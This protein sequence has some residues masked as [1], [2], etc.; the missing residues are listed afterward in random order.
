MWNLK[1]KTNEQGKQNRLIDTENKPMGARAEIL[2]G[3]VK[4]RKGIK[5]HRNTAQGPE[6]L[7]LSMPI[8]RFN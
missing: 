8:R 5:K 4:K 3:W 2:E 6:P 1:K 7:G